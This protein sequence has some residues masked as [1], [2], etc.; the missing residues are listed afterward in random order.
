[1]K[2]NFLL[3][4]AAIIVFFSAASLTSCAVDDNAA[5]ATKTEE[6]ELAELLSG[7]WICD[8]DGIE[9]ADFMCASYNFD[10]EGN[11]TIGFFFF[12]EEKDDY[13]WFNLGYNYRLLSSVQAGNR[14]LSGLELTPTAETLKE[15]NLDESYMVPDTM[16][17][18][19]SA[20]KLRTM[21]DVE[22]AEPY[23]YEGMTYDF[24]TVYKR[25]VLDISSL[26]KAKTKEYLAKIKQEL[27][28]IEKNNTNLART[29]A[30]SGAR[31]MAKWMKD[32]PGDTK[33]RDLLLPGSHDCGTFGL[34]G[35]Y[36][37]TFGRTQMSDFD[38]QFAWGSRVFDL[39]TRS[40]TRSGIT[41]WGTN[42]IFH[43]MMD[44][45]ATLEEALASIKECLVNNP[46]EG[47]IITIKG[48]GNQL[49][50]Y[51]NDFSKWL[52]K[53]VDFKGYSAGD[54]LA[55]KLKKFLNTL[56]TDAVLF[57][58]DYTPLNKT[59]TTNNTVSLV[60]SML[61]DDGKLAQFKP[62]MTMDDLRGKA[63]VIL[64]DYDTPTDGWGVLEDQIALST[65]KQYVTPKG[66]VSVAVEE[67][68][69]WDQEKSETE[70]AYVEGK[71]EKFKKLLT[72]CN[73]AE[74][75]GKW[76][77]NAC[78]GYFLDGGTFFPDY[79]SF[80]SRVYP[81]MASNVAATPGCRGICIQDY[82]GCESVTHAPLFKIFTVWRSCLDITGTILSLITG[83]KNYM[84]NVFLSNYYAAVSEAPYRNTFGRQLTEAMVERNFSN[85]EENTYARK[86]VASR[87]TF[88]KGKGHESYIQLFDGTT[89][90]KW[91]VDEDDMSWTGVMI[92][93]SKCWGVEFQT[94]A[95]VSP[96]GFTLYTGNDTSVFPKRNPKKWGLVGKLNKDD[97][98]THIAWYE[99]STKS[100]PTTNCTPVYMRLN[101]SN[102]PPKMQYFRFEVYS[103]LGDDCL[104]FS[105]F[106][107]N[108]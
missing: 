6:Q 78:N 48:E 102:I 36:M 60:K 39:R 34:Y 16:F 64:Q 9:D 84:R 58:V 67:Q 66:D 89:D 3:T 35:E 45:D 33:V 22:L 7:S 37:T 4:F 38:D 91:C 57:K 14:K 40:V 51:I 75:A 82:V 86:I 96:V 2:K 80:A 21:K 100:F 83:D 1:M 105:E 19:V 87:G 42:C 101:G 59:S 70:D 49:P 10:G 73:N 98:W 44:C 99:S 63:L 26:D 94:M 25:G 107:F 20:R 72:D 71:N 76:I 55:D 5:G 69:D 97:P 47:V 43:D 24:A 8:L 65:G 11:A 90:T 31:D 18:E 92:T 62:D 104:Q 52:D 46:S 23:V 41:E 108:Y 77:V 53:Q 13:L 27:N 29:R 79:I 95:P 17:V 56:Y 81:V 28:E 54:I 74:N 88:T 61:Y 85:S 106:E 32:I 93:D 15:L 12:D 68:N 103:N 30:A 50:N